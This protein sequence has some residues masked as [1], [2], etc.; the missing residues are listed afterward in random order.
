MVAAVKDAFGR[1]CRVSTD[2]VKMSVKIG[3]EEKAA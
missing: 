2:G 3:D 1:T